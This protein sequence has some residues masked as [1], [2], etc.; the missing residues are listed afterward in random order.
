MTS[1]QIST[2]RLVG[3]V[4]LT[5]ALP[6]DLHAILD[7]VRAVHLPPEGIAETIAYFWVAREGE[8][9]IGTVGLEVYDDLALLRS[10]AVTPE[11]QQTGLGRALTE[12]VLAYL[13]TR[14]YRAVYLLTSTAEAF[15][16]RHDFYLLAR[17]EVPTSVQQSVEFQGV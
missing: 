10:L 11:R 7:L 6:G 17:D 4:T 14:Q 1:G 2:T 8:R 16:A 5:P 15:F 3:A 12:T 9:I 13:T